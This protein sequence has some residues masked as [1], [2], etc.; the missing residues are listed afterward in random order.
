MKQA[1]KKIIKYLV[2]LALLVGA[3]FL[4]VAIFFPTPKPD[5]SYKA[6]A[7]I[8]QA[9][10]EKV[11]TSNDNLYKLLTKVSHDDETYDWA[12]FDKNVAKFKNVNTIYD[13]FTQLNQTYCLQLAFAKNDKIYNEQTK[14]I[15][16]EISN[17]QKIITEY[18]NY[19]DEYFDKYYNL[20]NA[21]FTTV[22]KE[23]V[24]PYTEALNDLNKRLLSSYAKVLECANKIMPSQNQ[25]FHNNDYV[26]AKTANLIAWSNAYLAN[27]DTFD[28]KYISNFEAVTQT[29]TFEDYKTYVDNERAQKFVSVSK[30]ADLNKFFDFAIKGQI[31][32]YKQQLE[33]AGNNSELENVKFLCF[34]FNFVW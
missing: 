1:A 30:I 12:K 17:T 29:L 21:I 27:F 13:T 14:K 9:D 16:S 23:S 33:E 7:T 8:N 4:I 15:K 22:T 20:N 2:I 3:G 10:I 19:L 26:Q 25:T 11:Q 28:G 18:K 32:T 31:E 6:L 34:H 5:E 24:A